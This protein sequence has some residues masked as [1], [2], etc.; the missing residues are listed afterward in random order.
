LP[1]VLRKYLSKKDDT[2]TKY[3]EG[4]YRREMIPSQSI[5]KALIEGK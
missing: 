3:K 5:K 1:K 2:F 4:T